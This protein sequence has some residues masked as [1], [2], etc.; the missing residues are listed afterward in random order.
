MEKGHNKSKQHFLLFLQCFLPFFKIN[1]NSWLAFIL[2][3]AKA[4]N[5][6]KSKIFFNIANVLASDLPIGIDN[7]GINKLCKWL[8]MYTCLFQ[9]A[10][11]YL[12]PNSCCLSFRKVSLVSFCSQLTSLS[13]QTNLLFGDWVLFLTAVYSHLCHFLDI[14]LWGGC[15]F[16]VGIISE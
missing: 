15:W 14:F 5:L 13:Y 3:S 10:P 9:R 12:Q 11:A 1:F 7:K 4:F 16:D 6:E 8:K 2:F